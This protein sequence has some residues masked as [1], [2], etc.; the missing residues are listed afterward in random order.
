MSIRTVIVDDEPL[1]RER[2]RKLAEAEGDLEIVAECA[3]G[4][5][6]VQA[7][8]EH[9]PDLVF[10]DIQ[11]PEMDGFAVLQEVTT[12]ELPVVVFVTAYSQHAIRAFEVH[13]L[14]YLLKPFT[15]TRFK[16]AVER[17]R[18]H[19][20]LKQTGDLNRKLT[21]L[22][23][24]IRPESR[25]PDRLAVRSGGRVFFVRI[26][27]IDWVEAADNYVNLHVGKESHLVRETLTAMEKRLE[28]HQFV[29]ISRSAL[30][31]LDRIRELQPLFHGDY[32]V[33][34][35]DGTRLNLSRTHR[36]R[37]RRFLER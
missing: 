10:L 21:N 22:L 1:A 3:D 27:D 16:Q 29:R 36:E 35:R 17:V 12:P 11:M 23:N 4:R 7:I 8:E 25:P 6:A 13:A 33:I 24:E 14:D 5:E 19:L 26:P 20:Q 18:Q 2:L 31:N 9:R 34:L 28:P 32:A 15:R 37:L 30:V